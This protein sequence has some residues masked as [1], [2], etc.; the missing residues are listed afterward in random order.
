MGTDF[1]RPRRDRNAE[2]LIYR[3]TMADDDRLAMRSELMDSCEA[4][5]FRQSVD[6]DFD[7]I[8]PDFMPDRSFQAASVDQRLPRTDLPACARDKS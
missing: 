3:P 1:D 6:A 8:R 4:G 2:R 5:A 7:F